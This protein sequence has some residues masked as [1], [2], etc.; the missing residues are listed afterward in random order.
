M[1]ETALETSP[2]AAKR[3]E[4]SIEHIS[5]RNA[6]IA[7]VRPSLQENV[8]MRESAGIILIQQDSP[9]S[10]RFSHFS[11]IP[12]NQPDSPNQLDSP[13]PTDSR[14]RLSTNEPP[15]STARHS[16][17][18]SAWSGSHLQEAL[19]T[20]SGFVGFHSYGPRALF[21]LIVV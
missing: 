12:S 20:Y 3:L 15:S 4:T 21:I 2:G 9:E 7:S 16:S 1:D 10:A 8:S 17:R 5:P 6:G 18:I 11:K 14:P 19:R 13:H